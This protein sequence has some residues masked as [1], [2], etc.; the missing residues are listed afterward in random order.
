M[1]SGLLYFSGFVSLVIGMLL[2]FS[3]AKVDGTF[4]LVLAFYLEWS[5]YRR[6]QDGE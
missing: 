1:L 5:A 6:E 4:F 2:Y 3:N